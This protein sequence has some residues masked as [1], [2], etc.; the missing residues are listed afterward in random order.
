MYLYNV[1]VQVYLQGI[2]QSNIVQNISTGTFLPVQTYINLHPSEWNGSTAVT[3]ITSRTTRSFHPM[4]NL[5]YV[6]RF[7]IEIFRNGCQNLFVFHQISLIDWFSLVFV[8]LL[9][10]AA[11][12]GQPED[13]LSHHTLQ[14][15]RWR[16]KINRIITRSPLRIHN[17][18]FC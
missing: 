4:Q 17:M 3:H 13:L 11:V 8:C 2:V 16:W 14:K 10:H 6:L 1:Q 12:S 7:H 18:L 9:C 5:R 15:S